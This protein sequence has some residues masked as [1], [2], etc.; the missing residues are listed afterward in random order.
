VLL[1]LENV[2][3]HAWSIEA[4]QATIRSSGLVFEPALVLVLGVDRSHFYVVA[5]VVHLI[6]IPVEVG[7]ILPE[8]EEPF[9]EGEPPLFLQ[10]SEIIHAKD[11][12]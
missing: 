7:G 2:A 10:A 3:A 12:L 11:T 8:P 6:L 9:M 4:V 5:W 1:A